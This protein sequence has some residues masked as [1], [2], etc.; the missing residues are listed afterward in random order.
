M[1]P[2]CGSEHYSD[3]FRWLEGY[4]AK[5][6]PEDHNLYTAKLFEDET[7]YKPLDGFGNAITYIEFDRR[8]LELRTYGDFNVFRA[9]EVIDPIPEFR[10][11]GMEQEL[12]KI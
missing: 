1:W 5:N 11:E 10:A 8:T 3:G 2:F 4:T 6:R 12:P 9:C 7:Y